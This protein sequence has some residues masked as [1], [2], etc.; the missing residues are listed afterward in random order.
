MKQNIDPV[1]S[2]TINELDEKIRN[3]RR[4]FHQF[5]ERSWEE[6]RT[7]ALV[8]QRLDELGY[9]VRLG[10]EVLKAEARLGLPAEEETNRCYQ[11]ALD[12]G[13]PQKYVE[14]MKDG[15]T[16]VVGEIGD[17]GPESTKGP[18]GPVIA[19]RF[20]MDAVAMEEKA[21]EG[22]LPHRKG[23]SSVHPEAMHSCGHDG[24]MAIGLGLAELLAKTYAGGGAPIGWAAGQAGGNYEM[25]GTIRLIFQPSEEGVGGAKAMVEAGV[26]DDADYLFGLHIGTA[27]VHTGEFYCGTGGFLA[28]SKLDVWFEGQAAHAGFVPEEGRNALLAAANAA[29]NLHA[30]PRHSGG[31]TRIN[32][33]V[34]RAGTGRNVVPSEAYLGIETRGADTELNDYMRDRAEKVIRAAAEMYGTEYRIATSGE[35]ASCDSDDELIE[36]VYYI[37]K[38]RGLFSELRKE[39]AHFGASE[40]FTLMMKRVQERGG[41]AT[42]MLLGSDLQGNHHTERFDFDESVLIKGVESLARI[43]LEIL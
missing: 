28:T 21:P 14:K 3:Y 34:M 11:R 10:R 5:A 12:E 30:I 4:D 16:G 38:R 36:K 6:Y 41:K 43:A 29:I 27:A 2:E 35:A 22:H 26:L 1:F 32:V 9:R 23:F 25:P 17:G 37:A 42:Y 24:H 31:S 18:K 15:F 8:A 13:A 7:A 39:K 20:D 33:G 40:D 19:F